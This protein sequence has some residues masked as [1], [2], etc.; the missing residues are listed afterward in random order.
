MT[1]SQ[2][3]VRTAT[4]DDITAVV[5]LWAAEGM[6]R[7]PDSGEHELRAFMATAPSACLVAVDDVGDRI[8]G[9][10]MA[11]VN[12]H[13]S[14]VHHLVVDPSCRRRGIGDALMDELEVRVQALGARR[15]NILVYAHNDSGRAFWA[16]RGYDE[17][18]DIVYGAKQ[19]VD[20]ASPA[21]DDDRPDATC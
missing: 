7:S 2:V 9:A 11:S 3:T 16:R 17:A 6:L 18:P 15:V 21:D 13:R 1:P 4:S 12:A 14:M 20:L 19:L 10:V 5:A 8:V